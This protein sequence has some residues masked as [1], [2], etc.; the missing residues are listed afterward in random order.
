MNG[1]YASG[2]VSS[3]GNYTGGLI[4]QHG[5]VNDS[6][7]TGAVTGTSGTGG[8]I[9]SLTSGAVNASYATGAVT[10]ITE[11]GRVDRGEQAIVQTSY[12]T[13]AVKGTRPSS[14]RLD[15]AERRYHADKL[16][17][18][19]GYRRH[20]RRR[21]AGGREYAGGNVSSSYATGAVAATRPQCRRLGRQQCWRRKLQLFHRHC[22]GPR[23]RRHSGRVDWCK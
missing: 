16:R 4:G 12:A 14:R 3:S 8:L 6:Y 11:Y 10:G 22:H 13:G 17:H 7:A 1:D 19:G 23:R 2:A 9:G 5:N 21:W 15:R 18:R 20:E